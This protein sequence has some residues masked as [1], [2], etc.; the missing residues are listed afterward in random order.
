MSGSSSPIGLYVRL[1]STHTAWSIPTANIP[2][3]E[4]C[5]QEIQLVRGNRIRLVEK[6]LATGMTL[7]G[8]WAAMVALAN[9]SK[10]NSA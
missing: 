2:A 9:P 8:A 4:I 6:V 5:C 7:R 1:A 3:W 10:E